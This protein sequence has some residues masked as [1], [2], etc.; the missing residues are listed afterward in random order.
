MSGSATLLRGGKPVFLYTGLDLLEQ[1]T[2][3]LAYPKNLSDPLLREWV[4]SP[5]NPIISPTTAN[6]IN[7]SSFRDPTTAWLGK[8][9]HWRMAVG[10]KRVTRGLAI[11]YRSKNFVDWAKAKHPLYSM[12]DTGMWECPDFYPVLNDGSIGIDTSVNG[13]PC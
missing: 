10:S 12:E 4:K 8:D 13:R 2:Q 5:K 9:G 7:S 11:L 1:Q 3:N 6:K